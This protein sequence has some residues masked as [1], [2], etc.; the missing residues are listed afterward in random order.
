MCFRPQWMKRR[1]TVGRPALLSSANMALA[2]ILT[3]SDSVWTSL[4][5]MNMKPLRVV[6]YEEGR[7][8][9]GM[10]KIV[11]SAVEMNR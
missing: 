7:G 6:T 1:I 5:P 9:K 8:T 10:N 11:I 3:T 2:M 4:L